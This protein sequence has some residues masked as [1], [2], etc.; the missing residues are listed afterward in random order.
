MSRLLP[1]DPAHASAQAKPLLAAVQSQL[2]ITPNFIK[3]LAHA[4]VALEGFLGL[5]VIASKGAL[6]AHTRERIALAVAEHN[7][8]QYCVS[9][10]TAIGQSVGLSESEIVAARRGTST[11]TK[12]A[13]AVAFARA[14]VASAGAVSNDEFQSARAVLSEEEIVEVIAHVSLNL[15][16]NLLGKSTRVA[17]DFPEVSLLKAA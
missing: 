8:C 17:I 11:D 13:V 9:A 3:V 4:P 12:A 16:T 2:G 6:D 14:L 1:V 10:H 15:F 5:Y 7:A